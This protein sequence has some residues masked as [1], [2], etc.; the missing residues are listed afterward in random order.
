MSSRTLVIA[1]GR[2][3]DP[4][5]KFAVAW[6]ACLLLSLLGVERSFA[7]DALRLELREAGCLESSDRTRD[8]HAGRK[9]WVAPGTE[10]VTHEGRFPG[11]STNEGKWALGFDLVQ[12]LRDALVASP[13]HADLF[14]ISALDRRQAEHAGLPLPSLD[15]AAAR[16][17]ELGLPLLASLG[18][19]PES[20]ADARGRILEVAGRGKPVPGTSDEL[21]R[22][23]SFEVIAGEALDTLAPNHGEPPLGGDTL[24]VDF[25]G[26]ESV[27]AT[28]IG[29][30]LLSVRVNGETKSV[31]DPRLW[32]RV[33]QLWDPGWDPEP[34]PDAFYESPS[35]DWRRLRREITTLRAKKQ[36]RSIDGWGALGEH[37]ALLEAEVTEGHLESNTTPTLT[38]RFRSRTTAVVDGFWVQSRG[39][40]SAWDLRVTDLLDR[41]RDV[42]ERLAPH[43]WLATWR[44]RWPDSAIVLDDR[45]QPPRLRRDSLSAA[46]ASAG[47]EGADVGLLRLA[48]EDPEKLDIRMLFGAA[49]QPV[50]LYD[51]GEQG[52]RGHWFDALVARPSSKQWVA[53]GTRGELR[54][55]A[56]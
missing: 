28:L 36:W 2:P 46:W 23:L 53:I 34:W 31:C 35:G 14:T 42:Q 16:R 50:L 18:L 38:G 1:S 51:S 33:F 19:A 39:V 21:E 52:R 29:R 20:V 30:R 13:D 25:P 49:G 3:D 32:A 11:R 17:M 41:W 47:L 10:V 7:W 4:F 54:H 22:L 48:A 43:R 15:A 40:D 56:P 55:V 5:M 8:Y 24:V 26:P 27:R 45:P 44:D 6:T 37:F 9:G 12:D